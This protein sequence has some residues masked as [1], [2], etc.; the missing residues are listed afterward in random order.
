[1]RKMKKHSDNTCLLEADVNVPKHLCQVT[2]INF[3]FSENQDLSLELICLRK[4][5]G[6]LFPGA[7]R[8]GPGYKEKI[9]PSISN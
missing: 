7:G 4:N 5:A 9:L 8:N 1:M 3:S 6:F 2:A